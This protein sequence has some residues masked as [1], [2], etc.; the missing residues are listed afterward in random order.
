MKI[1]LTASFGLTLFVV[2][3]LAVVDVATTP[4]ATQGQCLLSRRYLLPDICVNSC[5]PAFDCTRTT[6]PYMVFFTQA[7]S[8]MDAVIC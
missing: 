5:S 8:C 1:A 4:A 6:R 3:T 7:A 2:I